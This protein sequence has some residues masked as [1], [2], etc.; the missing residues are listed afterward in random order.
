MH[1][2]QLCWRCGDDKTRVF[3]SLVAKMSDRFTD[4]RTNTKFCVKLGQ[5]PSDICAM[6]YE[7]YGG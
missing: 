4:K 2:H 7:V 5:K 1:E 3:L 6:L